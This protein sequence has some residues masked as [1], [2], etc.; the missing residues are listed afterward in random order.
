LAC[1]VTAVAGGVGYVSICHSLGLLYYYFG[2][3]AFAADNLLP[4]ASL[5]QTSCSYWRSADAVGR[6]GICLLR[7]DKPDQGKLLLE[8]ARAMRKGESSSFEMFYEGLYC[9]F[10]E[11]FDQAVPLL[12]ASSGTLEYRWGVVRLL[13]V[14]ALE[15]NQ[16]Q[17]AERLMAPFSRAEVGAGDYAHA[18]VMSSLRLREGNRQAAAVILDRFPASRLPPFWE[19]RFEKLR[20]DV[21]GQTP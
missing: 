15:K 12:E 20:A 1:A 3:K 14:I 7:T 5:F 16:P 11:H 19:P 21:Q 18:Y 13:A 8:E 10:H 9:F 17:D 6:E 2:T 4:A